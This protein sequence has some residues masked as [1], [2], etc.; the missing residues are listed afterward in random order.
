MTPIENGLDDAIDCMWY[1][2]CGTLVFLMQAGF[3][4]LEVGSVRKKNSRNILIKNFMDASIG[5]IMW[6][7]SGYAI[8]F[9][10]DS[11][12]DAFGGGGDG[13]GVFGKP[14]PQG[15]DWIKDNQAGQNYFQ[16]WFFQFA[17][18]AAAVSITSGAVA[19]RCQMAAYFMYALVLVGLIYPVVVH[20]V[21]SADGW[22]S[23]FAMKHP[24][25][26]DDYDPARKW[27]S[28]GVIDFAGSGV[29]HMTGG[30]CAFCGAWVLGPRTGRFD[31][32]GNVVTRGFTPQSS[33]LQALGTF[34]LWFGWYA[35]N[36][37]STLGMWSGAPLLAA[38]CVVT[39]TL[40]AA[41]ASITCVTFGYI[42]YG[43]YQLGAAMNGVLGGLVSITAG[44]PVVEPW[45]AVIIGIIGGLVYTGWSKLMLMM[46][47]DDVVDA[48]AVHCACGMWGL[49]AAALFAKKDYV[50]QYAAGVCTFA[51][52]DAMGAFYGGNGKLLGMAN[53][54]ILCIWVWVGGVMFM[55][56]TI[57]DSLKL[58]RVS[59]DEEMFGL[60]ISHHG[61]ADEG[62]M[63]LDC[64]LLVAY[65]AQNINLDKFQVLAMCMAEKL[66]AMPVL[67]KFDEA[68]G[69][70]G[71]LDN[72]TDYDRFLSLI[73]YVP[74]EYANSG[75]IEMVEADE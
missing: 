26:G 55:M 21:W 41:A 68:V 33:A 69:K 72:E 10:T 19:E 51:S 62:G 65:K 40:S 52:E 11:G 9:G 8:A 22:L 49:W 27:V 61:G 66:D 48:V 17:F 39:T 5:A 35:F 70:K 56:F 75:Q 59:N 30:V 53:L 18:S 43:E 29:V 7:F 38:R 74:G 4:M 73:G 36:A 37:G 14:N 63:G 16:F 28:V 15:D 60:D 57:F 25:D 50:C 13:Y 67:Q 58:L 46:K 23:N 44:C 34:L 47:I 3:G 1:I 45:A 31:T 32:E 2:Y 24:S 54:L 42:M 71:I 12:R 64:E 6:W 20:W